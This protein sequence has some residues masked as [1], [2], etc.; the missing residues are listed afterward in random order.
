MT[1]LSRTS[2]LP[3]LVLALLMGCAGPPVKRP[4]SVP[5][6]YNGELVLYWKD[7]V[8]K[9]RGTYVE[10]LR[11]GEIEVFHK[12]GNLHFHGQFLNDRPHGELTNYHPNGLVATVEQFTYGVLDGTRTA[13]SANTGKMVE[14]VE[15]VAGIKNGDEYRWRDEGR[16]EFVGHWTGNLPS[17][18]WRHWDP[19]GR[20]VSE[21]HYWI[22]GG[23]P[24]GYLE[25]VY[26]ADGIA[27]VQTL[28]RREADVWEG[29]VTTWHG[30]GRQASLLEERGGLGN[31]RDVS[32]DRTGRLVS[33]GLR[34]NGD[35][36]GQW[37]FFGQL[38]EEV[39][40]VVYA[41]DRE[42]ESLDEVL[43]ER[44]AEGLDDGE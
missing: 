36:M 43:A 27:S 6:G 12:D 44:A 32:W 21:E 34:E 23:V 11:E 31:G 25:T 19:I 9:E 42:V 20:M 33:E 29:W 8:V 37:T 3:L 2:T 14:S 17:G 13:Y 40:T 41:H 22:I 24:T 28:K 16:K 10:G 35:R 1:S 15:Y 5:V 26:A 38:G 7:E 4:R 30:N 39:R 18:K